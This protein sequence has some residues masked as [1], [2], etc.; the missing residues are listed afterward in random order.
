MR[1]FIFFEKKLGTFLSNFLVVATIKSSSIEDR[2]P[3]VKRSNPKGVMGRRINR[4]G[5]KKS[6]RPVNLFR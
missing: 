3:Q 5:D 1:Q 6:S 4:M 2:L